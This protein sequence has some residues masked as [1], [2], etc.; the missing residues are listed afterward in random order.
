VVAS[1]RQGIQE[2]GAV[3]LFPEAVAEGKDVLW[4]ERLVRASGL[5][6]HLQ[7]EGSHVMITG[8]SWLVRIDAEV[9]QRAYAEAERFGDKNGGKVGFQEF[10]VILEKAVL[11]RATA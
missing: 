8:Q 2:R 3:N 10:G 6:Q 9:M 1:V 4:V 7:K 5:M 11:G